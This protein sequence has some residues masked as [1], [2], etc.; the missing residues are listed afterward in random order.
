MKIERRVAHE[1]RMEGEAGTVVGYASV[2]NTQTSIAGMFREQVAPGAFARSIAEGADVRALI[3]HDSSLIIGRSKAGTL[4]LAEDD[5]GLRVEIDLPDT[6]VAR[7]LRVSMARGDISQMSFGF[8]VR[9]E[10][11]D[12]AAP[13]PLRTITDVDLFDV[14]VVTF[15]QYPEAEAALRSLAAAKDHAAA[16]I[17]ARMRMKHGLRARA[18]RL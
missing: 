15:P 8:Y 4:R 6:Q 11:W 7:D 1:I 3:D 9:G 5:T 14:S 12:Q 2:F 16:R 18:A 10:H 17:A 13:P